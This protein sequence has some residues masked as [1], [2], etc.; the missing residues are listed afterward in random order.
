MFL[1]I[2]FILGEQYGNIKG[3]DQDMFYLV[4][5]KKIL[6]ENNFNLTD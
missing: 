4:T 2:N 5:K 1:Q 3:G 6:T